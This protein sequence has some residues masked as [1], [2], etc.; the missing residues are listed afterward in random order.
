MWYDKKRRS[1]GDALND[2]DRI[3]HL[4]R[5]NMFAVRATTT[6]TT[7]CNHVKPK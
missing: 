5:F 2:G 1:T 4:P 3:T 7:G 6:N